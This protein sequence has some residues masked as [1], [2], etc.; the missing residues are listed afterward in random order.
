MWSHKVQESATAQGYDLDLR[1]INV[2]NSRNERWMVI[3]LN[4][5]TN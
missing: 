5:A 1:I 2:E 4:I 3:E